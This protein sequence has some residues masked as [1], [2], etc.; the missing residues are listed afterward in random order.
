[1]QRLIKIGDAAAVDTAYYLI[2]HVI[3]QPLLMP[4]R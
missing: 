4:T 1:M 2:T 3:H